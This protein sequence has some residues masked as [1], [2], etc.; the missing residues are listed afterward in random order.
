MYDYD[1]P[2]TTGSKIDV[3]APPEHCGAPMSVRKERNGDYNLTCINDDQEIYT[4]KDGVLT[5][6]PYL[7]AA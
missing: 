4:D 2:L 1:S 6:P 7:T 5:E 3:A